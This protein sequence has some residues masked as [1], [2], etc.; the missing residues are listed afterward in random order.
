MILK[1]K[2]LSIEGDG[3]QKI[4]FKTYQNI[5]KAPFLIGV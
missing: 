5:Q 1:I 4:L 2:P 3:I